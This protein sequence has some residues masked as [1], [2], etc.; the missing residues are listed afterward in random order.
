MT[1]KM[2]VPTFGRREGKAKF[3]GRLR[4]FVRGVHGGVGV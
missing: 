2:V 3:G 1:V 4:E